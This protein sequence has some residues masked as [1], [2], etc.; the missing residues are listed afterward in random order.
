M[1]LIIFNEMFELSLLLIICLFVIND[2]IFPINDHENVNI[3]NRNKAYIKQCKHGIFLLHENDNYVSRHLNV[4]GE[5]AEQELSLFL[6]LI[7]K[8]DI[9]IDAGIHIFLLKIIS[10]IFVN[11]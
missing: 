4:Y 2:T 8:N 3:N 10:I 11:V 5:W 7:K 6:S 9:V 1:K